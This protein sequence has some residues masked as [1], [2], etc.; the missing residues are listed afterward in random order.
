MA[1]EQ[2]SGFLR[3]LVPS[4]DIGEV[5]ALVNKLAAKLYRIPNDNSLQVTAIYRSSTTYRFH[6]KDDVK[7]LISKSKIPNK[8]L[9]LLDAMSYLKL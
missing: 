9:A 7:L 5:N 4:S 3:L 1:D 8:G 6:L 2:N